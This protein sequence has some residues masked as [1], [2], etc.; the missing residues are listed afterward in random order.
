MSATAP[1][2]VTMVGQTFHAQG[3]LYQVDASGMSWAL[4]AG[5]LLLSVY[6]DDS[7]AVEESTWGAVKVRYR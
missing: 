5:G 4:P 7:V 3:G 2:D 6:V 1:F